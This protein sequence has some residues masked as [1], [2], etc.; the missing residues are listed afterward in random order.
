MNDGIIEQVGSPQEM[1]ENPATRFVAGF[2]GSPAMN[3][4]PC[5]VGEASGSLAIELG[6]GLALEAPPERVERYR[7]H[8]GREM[9]FGIRPEHL[10]EKRPHAGAGHVH[11]STDVDVVEPLGMDTMIYTTV[12]GTD[13]CAR[14]NPKAVQPVGTRMELTVDMNHMHLIDPESHR[15]V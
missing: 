4:V 12:N 6:D 11:F 15:V 9:L 13:V 7:Q 2:I 10:T 8:A 1:Y 3:F 14:S 5:R